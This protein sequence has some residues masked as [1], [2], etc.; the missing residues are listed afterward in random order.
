MA[1][2][3]A[4]ATSSGLPEAGC[5]PDLEDVALVGTQR[6][7]RASTQPEASKGWQE[8]RYLHRYLGYLYRSIWLIISSCEDLEFTGNISSKIAHQAIAYRGLRVNFFNFHLDIA[9][10]SLIKKRAAD[11]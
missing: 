3:G 2:T 1:A 6:R 5:G 7:T 11:F 9:D 4:G 8:R 10:D